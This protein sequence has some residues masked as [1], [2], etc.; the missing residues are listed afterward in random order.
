MRDVRSTRLPLSRNAA[1]Q[2]G[3]RRW[4]P[5]SSPQVIRTLTPIHVCPHNDRSKVIARQMTVTGSKLL[6]EIY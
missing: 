4:S 3:C 1:A 6:P 5:Y 2:H